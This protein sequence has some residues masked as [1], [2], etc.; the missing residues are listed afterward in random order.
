MA[1]A[2]GCMYGG[3]VENYPYGLT[4]HRNRYLVYYEGVEGQSSTAECEFPCLDVGQSETLAK[5]ERS[6]AAW[7]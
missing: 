3:T 5:S 7:N 6:A 1:M 2:I 4:G